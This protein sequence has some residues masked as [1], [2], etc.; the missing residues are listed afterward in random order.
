MRDDGAAFAI[1]LAIYFVI[2]N[3]CFWGFSSCDIPIT[4]GQKIKI[5][6]AVYEC[7]KTQELDLK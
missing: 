1:L 7:K 3:V 4:H 6:N 5:D 2:I